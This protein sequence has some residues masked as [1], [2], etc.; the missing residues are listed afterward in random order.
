VTGRDRVLA[1]ANVPNSDLCRVTK[2]AR[3]PVPP[4]LVVV[5]DQ[6]ACRLA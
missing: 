3:L 5:K 4:V 2:N 1:A 6:P